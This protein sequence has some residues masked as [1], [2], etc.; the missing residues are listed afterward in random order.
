[1]LP[2]PLL[3]AAGLSTVWVFAARVAIAWFSAVPAVAS[4]TQVDHTTLHPPDARVYLSVPDFPSIREAYGR[5]AL[6]KL[7]R[8]PQMSALATALGG[9]EEN[10]GRMLLALYAEQVEAGGAPPVIDICL[11][12]LRAASLSVTLRGVDLGELAAE[13]SAWERA[14]DDPWALALQHLGVLVD[15][16]FEDAQ[17]ARRAL[18]LLL[19]QVGSE[20]RS[21][22]ADPA[23][24][25]WRGVT[26]GVHLALC[27]GAVDEDAFARRVRGEEPGLAELGRLGEFGENGENE[28]NGGNEEDGRAA[29]S[30]LDRRGVT[31]IEGFSTLVPNLSASPELAR[32]APLLYLVEGFLGPPVAMLLRGGSWRVSILEDGRF[33][34]QGFHPL[35]AAHSPAAM[36]GAGPLD[37]AALDLLHPEAPVAWAARL[38]AGPLAGIGGSTL[39][40]HVSPDLV[41][42]LGST[43]TASLLAPRSLVTAP[44]VL[45]TV[46]L[47]DQQTFVREV[48][49]L[50]REIERRAVVS[51]ERSEYRAVPLYTLRF[52]A[53]L[54]WLPFDLAG[55][56]RPTLAVLE[57]RALLCLLPSHA[58]REVRRILTRAAQLPTAL[59]R[60]ELPPGVTELATADWLRYL[61]RIYSATRALLPLLPSDAANP[62]IVDPDSLPDV[63]S[64]T[65]H[66]QPS[67]RWKRVEQGGVLHHLESSFGPEAGLGL[68]LAALWMFVSAPQPTEPLAEE[69]ADTQRPLSEQSR[70]AGITRAGLADLTL[71]LTL[72]RLDQGHPPASL[73]HLTLPTA[74]YPGGFL[75]GRPVAQD[76]WQNAFRY[77]PGDGAYR[78][79]STGADGI[80]QNGGGDDLRA[81]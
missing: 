49:N 70:A 69:S 13:M 58:K 56:L 5:T 81:D 76:G 27:L 79:W 20:A 41:R 61:G 63:C 35:P 23:P 3:S 21:E 57:D 18:D 39:G 24:Q 55:F 67:L 40:G 43:L 28:Q 46:A 9:G 38:D 66:F 25:A 12:P 62:L 4:H 45:L 31:V 73:Q 44:P 42:S 6:G 17:A 59:E 60:G 15:L 16:E 65:R 53:L 71:A 8:D 78:L 80:D 11:R 47:E 22:G 75:N 32:L 37:E 29:R 30:R 50:L 52:P 72:Y 1:M 34:T 26:A 33:L 2:N 7:L 19:G 64:I 51:V 77:A 36:L 74:G 14:G 54:P 68:A 10:L 48:E